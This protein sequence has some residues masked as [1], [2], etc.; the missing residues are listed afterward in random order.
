MPG[1]VGKPVSPPCQINWAVT[2]L[3][4]QYDSQDGRDCSF[5]LSRIAYTVS[6]SY[7]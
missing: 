1:R 2:S 6:D 5:C 7:Q 3:I 4:K